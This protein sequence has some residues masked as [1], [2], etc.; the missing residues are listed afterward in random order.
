RLDP[1]N[2][3]YNYALGAV[4]LNE[5]KADEAIR[6]FRQYR[7]ARPSDPRGA[8]ALGVAY[9]DSYQLD[10]ARKE[11]LSINQSAETRTGAELY[12]G[13]VALAEDKPEEALAH[14][15]EAVKANPQAI[16]AY[17]ESALVRIRRAE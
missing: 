15:Q 4:L 11:L 12:L 13:R 10:L 5:K 14:F 3:Y 1:G 8:F 6:H 9:F 16:E 7:E 17:A 2:A